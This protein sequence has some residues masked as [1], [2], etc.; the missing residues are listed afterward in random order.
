MSRALWRRQ[1]CDD[2]FRN[3]HSNSCSG[4]QLGWRH[5]GET[6]CSITTWQHWSVQKFNYPFISKQL[7]IFIMIQ[8][9]NSISDKIIKLLNSSFFWSLFESP[10]DGNVTVYFWSRIDRIIFNKSF[11]KLFFWHVCL[12]WS[13]FHRIN[14]FALGNLSGETCCRKR[15]H[16]TRMCKPLDLQ[17]QQNDDGNMETL[18]K[19]LMSSQHLERFI[20]SF[21]G[22]KLNCLATTR[23]FNCPG[24]SNRL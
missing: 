23:R 1:R 22:L 17:Q 15:Q 20:G 5:G 9:E 4:K 18:R 14:R 24:N 3:T 21:I 6:N 19:R 2:R 16:F 13:T 10:Q 11:L 7:V 12:H 8:S